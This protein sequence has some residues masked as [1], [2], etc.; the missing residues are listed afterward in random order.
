M[1]YV[2]YPISQKAAKLPQC[3]FKMCNYNYQPLS[4]RGT[5]LNIHDIFHMNSFKD[6]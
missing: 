1:Q 4:R 2:S 6:H 3:T 5:R